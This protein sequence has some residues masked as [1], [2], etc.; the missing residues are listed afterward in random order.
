MANTKTVVPFT[1]T[2]EQE[3]RLQKVIEEHKGQYY[4]YVESRDTMTT[5]PVDIKYNVKLTPKSTTLPVFSQ[6]VKFQYG[7]EEMGGDYID[8]L[9]K[10]DTVEIDNSN[11]VITASQ[12]NKIAKINDYKNVTLAGNGWEFTVNVSDESTKNLTHSNAGIKEVLSKF[13]DQDFK[14][15]TFGAKPTFSGTGKL[16]LDV[17]DI[18]D[19]FD[20]MYTYRYADGKLYRINATFDADENTLSFRTNKLDNFLVTNELIKDGTV[21]TE[22]DNDNSSSS[23][24][25]ENTDKNN[26]TTG[27]NDMINVAVMAAIASLAA[28]GTMVTKKLSK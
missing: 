28:A 13:P 2:A 10:G 27:A 17:D 20:K 25:E 8:S 9:D 16:S 5:K 23:D 15:F 4:L 12:F 7:Y 26:P 22:V 3:Q 1:G 18:V 14:F 6:E 19:D 11:P 24:K 21:V